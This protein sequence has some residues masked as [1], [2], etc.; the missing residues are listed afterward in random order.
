M[1]VRS[2]AGIHEARIEQTLIEATELPGT[3]AAIKK[4]RE[5]SAARAK[6]GTD[7]NRQD[8]SWHKIE[9][10]KSQNGRGIL[11]KK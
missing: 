3:L 8:K 5:Y 2:E 4:S 11:C 10:K 1:S 6:E 7:F 9:G